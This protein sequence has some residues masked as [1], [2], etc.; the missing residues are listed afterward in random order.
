MKKKTILLVILAMSGATYAQSSVTLYGAADAGIGK[1]NTGAPG[2]NDATGRTQFISS[3][4][5]NNVGSH[6]GFRG[7]E[8]LG[9]GLKA[10]FALETGIDLD[11]GNSIGAGAGMWGRSARMWL[12]S[13]W[14]TLQLGRSLN[15][16]FWGLAN[17]ELTGAAVYSVVGSTYNWVG[18]GP[19]TNSL[20]TYKTPN[21]NGFSGDLGYTFKADNVIGGEARSKWDIHAKYVGGAAV[22][23]LSANQVQGAKTSY[24]LG[25]RYTIGD[26]TVAASLQDAAKEQTRRRGVTLG[27]KYASGLVS[28]ILDVTRDFKN[29][30]GTQK[31]TNVLLEGKYA[32]SK[33]SFF[34]A[35][36]LRWDGL[37]NYGVGV[38]HNF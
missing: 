32:L 20:I 15:A 23:A 11:E 14:G 17:W 8:D 21:L 28:V 16:S 25:S 9:G 37:N 2:G 5:M 4:L 29:D 10:G 31:Y 13:S 34:Y 26:F 12:E 1:I 6:I 27:G 33:R 18:N 7:I 3:S 36:Y 19:R 38:R 24:A 35:A 22:V 30:W